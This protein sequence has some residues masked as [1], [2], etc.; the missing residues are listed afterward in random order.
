MLLMNRPSKDRPADHYLYLF[1]DIK[2]HRIGEKRLAQTQWCAC[3]ENNTLLLHSIGAGTEDQP[4]VAFTYVDCKNEIN[5]HLIF[6]RPVL[7]I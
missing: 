2:E 3:S 1:V 4:R 7:P 6:D 5:T